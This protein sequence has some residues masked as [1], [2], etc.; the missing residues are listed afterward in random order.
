MF[1]V[2]RHTDVQ[3]GF[4]PRTG[5]ALRRFHAFV[6]EIRAPLRRTADSAWSSGRSDGWEEIGYFAEL[7]RTEKTAEA[8]ESRWKNLRELLVGLDDPEGTRVLPTPTAA[9]TVPA[10]LKLPPFAC[11]GPVAPPLPSPALPDHTPP[12]GKAERIPRGSG[13]G[14]GAEE[15]AEAG[16]AVTLITMHAA[17]GLEFPHVHIVGVE[18]GL[19]PHS[20]SKVEGTLDEER[21]LF[22]VAITRAQESL[23]VSHCSGRKRY[24]QLMPCHPSPFLEGASGGMRGGR[25]D[26]RDRARGQLG[27]WRLVCGDAGG[28]RV[29]RPLPSGGYAFILPGIPVSLD[30]H[31]FA[32]EGFYSHGTGIPGFS[33]AG[34]LHPVRIVG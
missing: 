18:D 11:R 29:T 8:A 3:A 33:S 19:L 21:R 1:T 22:Y 25:R 32:G 2:L 5:E 20:R 16:D 31:L 27:G 4:A 15:D 12:H 7:R 28:D 24:G 30:L 6:E 23:K 9:E 17:K 34:V 10:H 26:G 14:S 13:A